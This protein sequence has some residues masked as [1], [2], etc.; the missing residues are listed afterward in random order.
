MLHLLKSARANRRE[1]TEKRKM[2]MLKEKD[3]L[4]QLSEYLR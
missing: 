1:L 2:N 4:A 3:Y